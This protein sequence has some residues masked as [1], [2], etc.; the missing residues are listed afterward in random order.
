MVT[1]R[2]WAMSASGLVMMRVVNSVP[3]VEKPPV[4]MPAPKISALA[5][6]GGDGAAGGG[7]AGARG[8]G[9]DV[10][11]VDGVQ[12]AVFGGADVDVGGGGVEGDGDGVGGGGGGFD[13][14]GVVDGLAEAGAAGGGYGQ[15]VGV[16]GRV[17]DRGD[18]GGGV[19]PADGQDVG[20]PGGLRV[21]VGDRH[22]RTDWSAAPPHSPAQK[23]AERSRQQLKFAV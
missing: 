12:A 8:R 2:S 7:G 13:V 22:R 4:V 5:C 21:G 17:G 9:A 16:A 20:V 15:L 3:A 10:E 18:V 6:G 19:V 1:M 23:P 11:G 14:G